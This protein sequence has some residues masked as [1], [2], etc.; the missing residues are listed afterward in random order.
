MASERGALTVRLKVRVKNCLQS[1]GIRA[2]PPWA[3]SRH[4]LTRDAS[5]AGRP[6]GPSLQAEAGLALPA[7]VF[8]SWD[9]AIGEGMPCRHPGQRAAPPGTC[10]DSLRNPRPIAC[11]Y[12][13]SWMMC[14]TAGSRRWRR[15]PARAQPLGTRRAPLPAAARRQ[16]PP[17]GAPCRNGEAVELVSAG[18]ILCS[19]AA[20][21]L[22]T[23]L[24]WP[25][26]SRSACLQ[27][28]LSPKKGGGAVPQ[29]PVSP[30][31]HPAPPL[32][33]QLVRAAAD[34]YEVHCQAALQGCSAPAAS[35]R[36][37]ARTPP[38]PISLPP[39]AC[40]PRR[41]SPP[42]CS[43]YRSSTSHPREA[44][45]AAWA[46]R[47]PGVAARPPRC[48]VRW[49]SECWRCCRRRRRRAA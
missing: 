12:W 42:S 2:P 33:Q 28:P 11:R 45:A 43:A 27:P 26:S 14:K 18:C 7:V 41:C 5:N 13:S 21:L 29:S 36:T 4:A 38:H 30:S 44:A 16:P 24:P 40:L 35:R 32:K 20:L 23:P 46:R 10:D 25:R 8:T 3:A 19:A 34:V 48:S 39:A 31:Y 17:A 49:R 15:A 6:A 47:G 37:L 9:A 1:F 22:T